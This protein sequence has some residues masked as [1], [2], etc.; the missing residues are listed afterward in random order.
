MTDISD[1]DRETACTRRQTM[2]SR[3]EEVRAWFI[4]EVL[5]LEVAL[6]K[7][8]QANWRGRASIGDVLHDVYVKVI[9]AARKEFPK[10]AAPFVFATARNLLVD[11]V[12]QEKVIPFEAVENLEALN[13]A[14]DSPAPDEQ[15]IAREELRR[16][17]NALDRLHPKSKE[18]FL[19]HHVEGL[20]RAEISVRL[21]I[22]EHTV[23][24]YLNAGVRL[25][26]DVLY[27]GS[28][29]RDQSK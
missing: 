11:R 8:L 4:Q 27:R 15:V 7:Y 21:G 28:Q 18:A 20:S 12:R 25:L 14:A 13:I 26:A 9:D 2:T 17:Q 24:W 1:R 10:S 29:D 19:L 5:P 3:R 6:T 16:I 22:A 23:G